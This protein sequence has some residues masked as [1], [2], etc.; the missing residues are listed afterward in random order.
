M[1]SSNARKV[2]FLQRL[3]F[4]D[5]LT[6][7][8]KT[9]DC[10]DH[11]L[12]IAKVNAYGFILPTLNLIQHYLSNRKQIAKIDSSYNEWVEI[13]FRDFFFFFFFSIWVFFHEHSRFTGQQGKGEGIYL[14]PLYHFHP[15]HR[16]LDISRAIAAESSP[17]HISGSRTRTGNLWF[18]S[19]S[20]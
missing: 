7:L 2:V 15:L 16:H 6:D 10:L 5:L 19:A 12:L 13:I 18:P 14:T 20:R 9:F 4:V 17:L 3:N 1:S 8:S 11:E